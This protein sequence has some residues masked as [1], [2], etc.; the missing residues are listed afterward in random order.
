MPI[1]VDGRVYQHARQNGQEVVWSVDVKTGEVLW[2]KE[3]W[4][5]YTIPGPGTRHGN[6]PN[7]NPASSD[8]RLFTMSVTGILSAWDTETGELL[9][10]RDYADHFRKPF[11][12]WGHS[13]SPLID[14][15]R[16]VIHFGGAAGGFLAALDVATG[17]EVWIQGN[18]G[19]SHASP[20]LAEIEGVRQI[21]EWNHEVVAGIESET[22]QAL[23]SYPLPHRG[24]NQNS[25]TPVYYRGQILVGAENRGLRSLQPMRVQGEW[26]VREN[27]HRRDISLNMASAVVSGD[28][29]FGKSQYKRGQFFR[30]HIDSS[31]I[32]WLGPPRMGEYAA[33][34]T[35]PGQILVLRNNGNLQIIP[36]EE[37]NYRSI[38]SYQV[39]DSPTWAAP[40]LLDDGVLIKDK[41]TLN[42]WS[43]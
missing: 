40:V 20:I 33:F 21:V 7:S 22:G 4:V 14:G 11:P 23:W 9:W 13:T 35:I 3:Y 30:L 32:I 38:A 29:L 28:S 37:E 27:W 26:K 16:V 42:R 25:P 2:R 5:D 17:E 34:L 6:G 36:A 39:A 41:Y 31:D 15:D 24:S 1:V 10:R 19:A 8:G 12:E 43:F 18:D